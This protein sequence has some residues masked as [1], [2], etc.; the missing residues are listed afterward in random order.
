[1][2]ALLAL[3]KIKIRNMHVCPGSSLSQNSLHFVF[4]SKLD[5]ADE[6]LRCPALLKNSFCLSIQNRLECHPSL[7]RYIHKALEV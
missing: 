1:M 4:C 7:F 6:C 5:S 2:S 3:L